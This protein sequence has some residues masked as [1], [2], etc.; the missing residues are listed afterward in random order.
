VT[1]LRRRRRLCAGLRRRGVVVEVGIDRSVEG[2]DNDEDGGGAASSAA[3]RRAA[4]LA[5]VPGHH[6]ITTR[7]LAMAE[8]MTARRLPAG[9][10]LQVSLGGLEDLCTDAV[11]LGQA[12]DAAHITALKLR[13]IA[14]RALKVAGCKPV[15]ISYLT[16]IP[17]ETVDNLLRVPVETPWMTTGTTPWRPRP[18][19]Q[20]AAAAGGTRRVAAAVVTPAG[21]SWDLHLAGDEQPRRVRTLAAAETALLAA[22]AAGGGGAGVDV[23][24]I[25]QL[26]DGCQRHLDDSDAATAAADELNER[27]ERTAYL[28]RLQVAHRLR[29][30][31]IGYRDIG[32]L[33]AMHEHR[34]RLLLTDP[35][36]DR[37]TAASGGGGLV[38]GGVELVEHLS[39]DPPSR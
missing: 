3:K 6:P 29:A 27:A 12:A 17:T 32:Y 30:F 11:E 31:G 16:G 24:V 26:G 10:D 25:A 5:R 9:F 38:A 23:H 18:Q 14:V 2:G 15:D 35:P 1:R 36:P 28:L 22:A 34:A 13:R 21:S 4:S 8:T 19:L 33:L 20:A 39:A 37:T 7:T